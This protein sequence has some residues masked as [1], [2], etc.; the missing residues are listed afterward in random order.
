MATKA[1][2]SGKTYSVKQVGSRLFYFS[3]RALRWLPIARAKV[4]FS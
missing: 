4:S 1:T 3:P 2:I